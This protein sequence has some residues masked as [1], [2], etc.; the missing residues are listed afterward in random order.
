[1]LDD[2]RPCRGIIERGGTLVDLGLYVRAE[3]GSFVLAAEYSRDLFDDA[4]IARLLGHF[5]TLLAA[6]LERPNVP[7]NALPLLTA[8]ERCQLLAHAT[9]HAVRV[10]GPL[11]V[12]ELFE[13]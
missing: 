5:E 13:A 3:H 12:H 4:T 10:A 1:D 11:T 6:A 8:D 2:A 7:V 9:G